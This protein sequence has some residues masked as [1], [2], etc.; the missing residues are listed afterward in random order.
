MPE[1]TCWYLDT[2]KPH[3]AINGGKEDRIHLVIDLEAN[4]NV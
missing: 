3:R 4:D 2:R 1:G